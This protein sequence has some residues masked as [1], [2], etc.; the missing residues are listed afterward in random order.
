[1]FSPM[2]KDLLIE[3]LNIHIGQSA[4]TLS[5]MINERVL[6]SIPEMEVIKDYNTNILDILY[7]GQLKLN[8][9]LISSITFG[10]RFHGK[11]FIVFPPINARSLINACLCVPKS[12]QLITTSNY[13]ESDLDILKEIS[14]VILNALIGEFGN[15]LNIKMEYTA[16]DIHSTLK[17]SI[18]EIISFSKETVILV[19]HSKF[20]LG[21]NEMAGSILVSLG[22]DSIALMIEKINI[23]LGELNG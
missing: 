4:N 18:E 16:P 10:K 7:P 12:A 23:L 11:A 8:E 15:L 6:L 20:S 17:S 2:Q 3:L 13:D 19:L 21:G 5:E 14:N 22:T 1:M 9:I